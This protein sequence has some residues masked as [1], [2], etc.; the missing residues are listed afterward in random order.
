[1]RIKNSEEGLEDLDASSLT[2]KLKILYGLCIEIDIK[3]L[4]DS[5]SNFKALGFYFFNDFHAALVFALANRMDLMDRLIQ[6]TRFSLPFGFYKQKKLLLEAV[7]NYY[8]GQYGKVVEALHQDMD[9]SFMG[10][11]TAQRRIIYEM[12]EQSKLKIGDHHE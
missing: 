10:G 1:M 11:S 3:N 4:L 12:L 2:F 6:V 9:C 8:L 7:K 5:W